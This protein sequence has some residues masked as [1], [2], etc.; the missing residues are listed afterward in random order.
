MKRN[1]LPTREELSKRLHYNRES[2]VL[3]WRTGRCKGKEAGSLRKRDGYRVIKLKHGVQTLAH[4]IIWVLMLDHPI[5][6]M[7]DHIDNNPSNNSWGNLR[8][9]DSSLNQH[10][11]KGNRNNTSGYLGVSW[12][13]RDRKYQT[14]IKLRGEAVYLGYYGCPKEASLEIERKRQSFLD[15]S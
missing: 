13:K 15:K 7:I 3:T 9:S 11:L 6:E 14:R 1:V 10:N 4:R 12:H 2:G 8:A 5:P